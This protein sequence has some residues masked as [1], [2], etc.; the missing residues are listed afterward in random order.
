MKKVSNA[1]E[2]VKMPI[3]NSQYSDM[4]NLGGILSRKIAQFCVIVSET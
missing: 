1:Y 4:L 2:D 3:N